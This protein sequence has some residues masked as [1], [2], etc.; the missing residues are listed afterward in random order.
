VITTKSRS[1]PRA[2]PP[3]DTCGELERQKCEAKGCFFGLT[4]PLLKYRQFAR[5][6]SRGR[7]IRHA[8]FKTCRPL[9]PCS[10]GLQLPDHGQARGRS[11]SK[12]CWRRSMRC[13]P[14]AVGSF[15]LQRL[16]ALTLSVSNARSVE[17]DLHPA[18]Q[19][20]C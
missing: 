2:T 18:L 1:A 20:P 9:Y 19:L 13:A 6:D 17:S 5:G 14:N 8:P 10:C 15:L 11:I 4:D 16:D 12:R 3:L 7:R